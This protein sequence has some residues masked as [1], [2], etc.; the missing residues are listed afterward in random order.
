ML[1]GD[2]SGVKD[3]KTAAEHEPY[4]LT[5]RT[6]INHPVLH[7][8][9]STPQT[10]KLGK[11]SK[12]PALYFPLATCPPVNIFMQCHVFFACEPVSH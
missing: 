3:G 4:C 5:S 1:A 2:L 7:S 6:L 10:V 9:H 12:H 11:F 8:V